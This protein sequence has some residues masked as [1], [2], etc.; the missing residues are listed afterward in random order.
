MRQHPR[1]MKNVNIFVDVDLTLVDE[2]GALRPG[3]PEALRRLKGRG[4]RLFLWTSGGSEYARTVAA[5]YGLTDL[6]DAFLPKPD[7]VIDDM[8]GTC[9]APFVFDAAGD[10]QS[11]REVAEEIAGKYVL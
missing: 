11:W 7:I 3:A 10:G 4:C 5:T 9:V 8:P 2:L 1:R 6:F